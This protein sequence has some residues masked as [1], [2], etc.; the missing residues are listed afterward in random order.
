MNNAL[1]KA[2]CFAAA[3]FTVTALLVFLL[4]CSCSN[5]PPYAGGTTTETTNGFTAVIHKADGT[6]A[7]NAAVRLRRFDYLAGIDSSGPSKPISLS[8][9][10]TT[11][12]N[13]RFFIVPPD[14]GTYDIEVNDNAGH[15]LLL[16]GRISGSKDTIDFGIGTLAITASVTGA[17][18]DAKGGTVQ[19]YGLER[20][21]AIDSALG[22]FSFND[23]PSG[24]YTFR[25]VPKNAS[26]AAGTISSVTLVPGDMQVVGMPAGWSFSKRL[27]FNTTISGANVP[28]TVLGFPVLVR[29]TQ[30]NFDFSGTKPNGEDLR[31][32]KANGLPLPYEIERWDAAARQAE[33][34]VKVDTVYGNDSTHC[35]AMCWGN[36]TATSLSDGAAVFD[37]GTTGGFKAV[38]HLNNG[39]NDAS[40][41][42][43]NGVDYG[44]V[45]TSGIIGRS[46]QFNGTDSMRAA[47]LLGRPA[48]VTLCAWVRCD[49]A[50]A[51]EEV[52][53]I[54][55]AVII[56]VDD[57]YNGNGT[58]GSIHIDTIGPS[59]DSAFS[60]AAT[61]SYLAGTGWRYVA[62]TVDPVAHLRS[63]YIDG[64][65][66]KTLS[67]TS[68]ISYN[69]VGVNT[70]LGT[71]GNGE[72]GHAFIGSIDEVRVC[73]RARSS[74][75][76]KLC[77]MSQRPDAAW[78]K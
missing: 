18:P 41:G 31:F 43:N 71:H 35:I 28:G 78:C 14:T 36:S 34:W 53:S 15:A 59:H 29:L 50:P 37:S 17:I 9:D 44:T 75:W 54:G 47:G 40:A 2:A 23:L 39:C 65:L 46:R 13:G 5:M 38:W 16:S 76:I 49:N 56:R 7:A 67:D 25:F 61:G 55:D 20:A 70:L 42:R 32:T 11:D 21:A 51:G 6:P 10:T 62:F 22:A 63:F 3:V 12:A 68:S 64:A 73:G 48:A 45:D 57:R 58:N 77:Y 27:Y 24:T 26:P 30:S 60:V 33:V 1:R 69:G 72:A 19:I 8:G 52:V 4:E 66:V 74:D